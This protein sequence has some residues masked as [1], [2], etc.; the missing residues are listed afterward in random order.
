MEKLD[1][2]WMLNHNDATGDI[3]MDSNTDQNTITMQLEINDDVITVEY[4]R[5]HKVK[6]PNGN[7]SVDIDLAE[8]F[9]HPA[10]FSWMLNYVAKKCFA[11]QGAISKDK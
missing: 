8:L 9:Q 7:G 2:D 5:Y 11:D 1:S 4:P 10:V 6:F 3:D